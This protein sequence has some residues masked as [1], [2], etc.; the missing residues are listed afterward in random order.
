M[1]HALRAKFRVANFGLGNSC[2]CQGSAW[3]ELLLFLDSVVMN[4]RLYFK[5]RRIIINIIIINIILFIII[6][7]IIYYYY[8]DDDFILSRSPCKQAQGGLWCTIHY[9][10]KVM[11]EGW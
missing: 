4:Q 10:S 11:E 1:G 6:L 8:Y 2:R 7:I 9:S 3:G 5:G